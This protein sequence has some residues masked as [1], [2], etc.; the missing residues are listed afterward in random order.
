MSRSADS[1]SLAAAEAEIVRPVYFAEFNFTSGFARYCSAP[2]NLTFD[3][4]GD[5]VKETFTGVGQLGKIGAVNEGAEL[6]RYQMELQLSGIDTATL[7]VALNTHYQGRRI[8]LWLGFLNAAHRLV[9]Q[10]IPIFIGRMNTMRIVRGE[11][12]TVTV[13]CESRLADWERPNITRYTDEEQQRRYPGD[14]GLQYVN[15]M[16][17]RELRWGI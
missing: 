4:N 14:M 11:T 9:G 8:K 16:V 7:S 17:E 10:P 15:Q 13:L 5:A 1:Q 12:G 3:S 2:F 6:Q